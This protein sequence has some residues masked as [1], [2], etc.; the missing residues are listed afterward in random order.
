MLKK[1]ILTEL[2]LSD[3]MLDVMLKIIIS[4]VGILCLGLTM[5]VLRRK[6]GNMVSTIY[7]WV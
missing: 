2:E 3:L 6:F 4:N 1:G 5:L 7:Q